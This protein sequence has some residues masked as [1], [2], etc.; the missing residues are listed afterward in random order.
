MIDKVCGIIGNGKPQ[1]GEL[2]YRPGENMALYAN[3]E[4]TEKYLDWKTKTSLEE[5]LKKT[6]EWFKNN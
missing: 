5:G 6:I 3:L 1:Y 2:N 4:K